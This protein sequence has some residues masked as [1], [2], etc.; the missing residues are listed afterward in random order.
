MKSFLHSGK[1]GDLVFSLPTIKAM[2]GGILY[3]PNKALGD[4]GVET[5]YNDM[6]GF[7]ETQSYINEVRLYPD[8]MAWN[9][10][11]IPVD[12]NLNRHITHPTRGTTNMVQRYFDVFG[13]KHPIPEKWIEAEASESG[14][15]VINLTPRFRGK[16]DWR[17]V[18]SSIKGELIFVGTNEEWEAYRI[19]NV[20]QTIRAHCRDVLSLC[21]LVAH[22]DAVYCN[23]SLVLA[24]AIGLNKKRYVEFKPMKT[25]CKFYTAN[26]YELL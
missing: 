11:P 5:M 25:N 24:L 4:W 19:L 3:L 20:R 18:I 1:Y 9:D 16:V 7:L 23:Q 17:R 2:G 26:E 8:V 21:S 6:H 10:T 15:T 22:A 13:I 12:V 14:Y